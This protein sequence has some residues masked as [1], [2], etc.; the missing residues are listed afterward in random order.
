MSVIKVFTDDG[1]EVWST[2]GIMA[3]DVRDI[4]CPGNTTGSGVAAGIRRATE[5]AEVIQRGGDPERP[6]EKAMRLSQGGTR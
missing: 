2:A 6:S 1:R 5:D 3:H 4:Q